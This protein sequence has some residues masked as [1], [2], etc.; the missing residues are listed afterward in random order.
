[1]R[2]GV[3]PSTAASQAASVWSRS[4]GWMASSQPVPAYASCACPVNASQPGCGPAS[5]P[6]GGVVQTMAAVASTSER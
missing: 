1:M 6:E 5:S 3:R 2:Y 4:S